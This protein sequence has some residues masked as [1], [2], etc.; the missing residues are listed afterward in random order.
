MET[1]FSTVTGDVSSEDPWCR[2]VDMSTMVIG[3]VKKQG[4]VEDH[5]VHTVK[6][7]VRKD[8]YK[9]KKKR[10]HNAV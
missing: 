3:D 10:S 2:Q 4:L 5:G 7:V 6:V 8:T 9:K 1:T